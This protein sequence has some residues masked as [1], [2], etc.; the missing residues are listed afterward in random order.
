MFRLSSVD[1]KRQNHVSAGVSECNIILYNQR[2]LAE[3]LYLGSCGVWKR[4]VQTDEHI[5]RFV[6]LLAR[7]NTSESNSKFV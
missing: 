4:L 2:L 1:E 5:F 6:N 7:S 3:Q